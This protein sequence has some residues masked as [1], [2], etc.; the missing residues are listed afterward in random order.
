MK[1]TNTLSFEIFKVP[2][3]CM[4]W[5][6][7]SE[8]PEKALKYVQ[9][10]RGFREIFEVCAIANDARIQRS[11]WSMCSCFHKVLQTLLVLFIQHRGMRLRTGAWLRHQLIWGNA[12][13]QASNIASLSAVLIA[14]YP[15]NV[16]D[17]TIEA[18]HSS[19]FG[20]VNSS[21]YKFFRVRHMFRIEVDITI[22]FCLY[23][24]MQVYWVVARPLEC[25]ALSVSERKE[26]LTIW[27]P[28]F[29]N[30]H[31]QTDL[32]QRHAERRE[33]SRLRVSVNVV[34]SSFAQG[35]VKSNRSNVAKIS[36]ASSIWLTAKSQVLWLQNCTHKLY[37]VMQPGY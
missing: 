36:H 16:N 10:I 3:E 26:D 27:K 9:M 34:V 4:Y 14:E 11:L 5:L 33:A 24:A 25:N 13:M 2:A 23:G 6:G 20:F 21:L 17:I 8:D 35:S 7:W 29:M 15:G 37:H 22:S 31:F 12:K 19:L 1:R 28:F 18:V 30:S 32:Q